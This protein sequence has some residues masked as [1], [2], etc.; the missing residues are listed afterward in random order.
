M[1]MAA[2][3]RLAAETGVSVP[4]MKAKRYANVALR[5]AGRPEDVAD[6][7]AYLAGPR[8]AYITGAALP[9]SGGVPPGI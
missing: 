6:T 7:V 3:T 2:N 8:A 4:E 5:D 1:H 9:V